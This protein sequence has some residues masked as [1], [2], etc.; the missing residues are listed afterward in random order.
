[1]RILVVNV[2]TTE[3]MTVAIGEQARRFATPGT[4]IIALTPTFGAEACE[5]N[6]DS[7][8]AA[9]AVAD[10]VLSYQGSYDA[11]VQAGFGEHGREVLQEILD[12]PVVDITEA[13]AHLACLLGR[14]YSV[15]TTLK[16]SISLIED[17][18]LLAG[19]DRTCASV[20]A[21]GVEVLELAGDR[22]RAVD[23]IVEQALIAVRR[24]R[25]EVICVGCAGMAD[26]AEQVQDA[27]GVPVVDGV[28]AAV[29]LAESL[30]TLG[31][32]TSKSL[33]Y[34]PPRPKAYHGWPVSVG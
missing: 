1:M 6:L 19:L 12:V 25:A 13:A 23:A 16:R 9:I 4:E 7:H 32:S 21:S 34:A 15:I 26:L 17:R 24:D 20:L 28:S 30:V 3:S 27:V 22:Q 11:V 2:N 29:K 31:L 18:L 8:L 10:R 14:R 5:S 33:T